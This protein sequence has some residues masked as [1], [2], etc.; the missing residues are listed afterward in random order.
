MGEGVVVGVGDG[1]GVGVGLGA[2]KLPGSIS[3]GLGVWM[4]LNEFIMSFAVVSL[5]PRIGKPKLSSASRS[6][7]A[8]S[9]C[10]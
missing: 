9:Y 5:V 8:N 1:E 7:E 4:K 10:V 3:G 6:I 2:T